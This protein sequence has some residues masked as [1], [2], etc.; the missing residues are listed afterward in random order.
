MSQLGK[1]KDLSVNKET[2]WSKN[3]NQPYNINNFRVQKTI[4]K[5]FDAKNTN[6]PYNINTFQVQ[7][8]VLKRFDAKNTNQLYNIN[9]FQVQKTVLKRFLLPSLHFVACCRTRQK[10]GTLR[11]ASQDRQCW[12]SLGP[13]YCLERKRKCIESFYGKEISFQSLFYNYFLQLLTYY[14]AVKVTGERV[15]VLW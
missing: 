15:T 13:T 5:R 14:S 7:K 9:T 3:R 8:T 1:N 4:L 2:Q 6:Q 11:T 12:S 10:K